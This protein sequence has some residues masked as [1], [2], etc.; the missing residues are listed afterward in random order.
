MAGYMLWLKWRLDS[1]RLLSALVRRKEVKVLV[2]CS[3]VISSKFIIILTPWLILKNFN[4][5]K[6]GGEKYDDLQRTRN[7]PSMGDVVTGSQ[8]RSHLIDSRHNPY[9]QLDFR[10][11]VP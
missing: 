6:K 7:R 10:Q 3:F 2:I 8:F 1:K 4:A 9:Y 11:I 5:E